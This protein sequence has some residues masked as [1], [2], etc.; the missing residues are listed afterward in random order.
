M[1]GPSLDHVF[2][3][4][5]CTGFP[6]FIIQ[7]YSAALLVDT[8][9]VLFTLLC[10]FSE[11]YR[12]LFAGLLILFFLAQ[13]ITIE[14]YACSHTKSM[15]ALFIA[16]LP[17]C[18]KR[19]KNFYLTAEFSRYFLLYVLSV[20]AFYKLYNGAALQP[21][22]FAVTLVNQHTDLATLHPAHICYQISSYLVSHPNI[23]GISYILLFLTQ[24]A[25]FIGFFTKKYDRILFLLLVFFV[26]FT[27]LIMRIYNYDILVLGLYLLFSGIKNKQ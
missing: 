20:S 5:H 22:N 15:S 18:F 23:A 19:E 13:R 16:L 12:H 3:L 9:V 11:K 27:Y 4:S 7:H 21:Q 6:R 1:K 2:W 24:A 17:F 10:F 25:F 8:A 14:S 26:I